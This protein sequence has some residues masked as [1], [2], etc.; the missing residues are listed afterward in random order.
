MDGVVPFA[1]TPQAQLPGGY[2]QRPLL[3]LRLWPRR[4]RDSL[5]GA[6]SPGEV[7]ASRGVAAPMARG[8]ACVARSGTLLSHAVTPPQRSVC[9]SVP[10][11]SPFLGANR[12]HANRLRPRRLPARLADTVGP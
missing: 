2:Q 6:V 10:T 4:R 5:R 1:W 8:G 11:R 9:L 3:L 7:L 12:A